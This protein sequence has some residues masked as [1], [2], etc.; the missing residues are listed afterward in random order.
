[1]SP[2]QAAGE[3]LCR[4]R[5]HN[6]A[7]TCRIERVLASGTYAILPRPIAT[8]SIELAWFAAQARSCGLTPMVL[9]FHADKFVTGNPTKLAL[10][11]MIFTD[12]MGRRGGL[13][14]RSLSVVDLSAC[15]GQRLSDICT[16]WGQPLI[17]FHHELL[18]ACPNPC[19]VLRL[20]ASEWFAK[21]GINA[22]AY[23]EA[24]LSLFVAHA[25]LF[26]AFDP[27]TKQESRFIDAVVLPAYQAVVSKAH[28]RPL[29]CSLDPI[30]INKLLLPDSYAADVGRMVEL[31]SR[32]WLAC[33]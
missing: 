5:Q 25:V 13:R 30:G 1:M 6:E 29:I 27:T 20:D 4:R 31:R 32:T 10:G 23:Y 24:Y 17:A 14:T 18:D 11:K 7:A 22:A 8:P 3:L 28:Q 19:R 26:E 15:D 9:E 2:A 21:N 16:H 12:G 33:R